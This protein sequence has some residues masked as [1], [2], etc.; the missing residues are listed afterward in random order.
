MKSGVDKGD[1]MDIGQLILK[2]ADLSE[3]DEILTLHF[4]YHVDTIAEA[5]KGEGFITT[6]FTRRQMVDLIEAEKG[7]FVAKIDGS[8]V[9]YVMA[10]SWGYWSAWPMFAHIM[11]SLP[12]IKYHGQTLSV[13]NSYQYGP[14]CVERQFRGS[15]VLEKIFEFAREEMSGRFKIL[16]TFV[17]KQNKR[18]YQAHRRKLGLDVVQTFEFNGNDYYEM[19]CETK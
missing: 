14:V 4:K 10:A 2:Y 5:D 7:L 17:N 1:R 9:A 15:G 11:K 8:V 16:V 3:I 19:A 13:E 12:E 18:S 6:P